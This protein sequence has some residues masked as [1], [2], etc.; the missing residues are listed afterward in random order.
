MVDFL[1][2]GYIYNI[3]FEMY[4]YCTRAYFTSLFRKFTS[5]MAEL[6]NKY[7]CYRGLVR[8]V[9]R[10]SIDTPGILDISTAEPKF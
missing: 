8:G 9:S 3:A 10:V 7:I 5:K 6:S 4:N 1:N 2:H